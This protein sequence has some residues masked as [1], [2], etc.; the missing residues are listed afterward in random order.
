MAFSGR[1][2]G[3]R[4]AGFGAKKKAAPDEA[5]SILFG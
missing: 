4:D 3:V 5:A 2:P 1:R